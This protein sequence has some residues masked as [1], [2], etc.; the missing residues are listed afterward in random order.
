MDSAGKRATLRDALLT[1]AAA[2]HA[3]CS[4]DPRVR[5]SGVL[6]GVLASD[7]RLAVRALR[8]FCAALDTEFLLPQPDAAGATLAAMSG[9]IYVKLN[10]AARTCRAAQYA[11]RERGVLVQLGAC[12]VG[13]LPLGLFDEAMAAPAPQLQ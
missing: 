1:V 10:A 7:V 6:L 11:G 12:Q 2:P 9:P 4:W 5:P 3:A 8:D 13:H